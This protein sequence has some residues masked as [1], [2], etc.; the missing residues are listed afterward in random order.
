MLDV[1]R[2]AAAERRL[3]EMTRRAAREVAPPAREE[4]DGTERERKP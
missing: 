1:A 3:R 4:T 2:M